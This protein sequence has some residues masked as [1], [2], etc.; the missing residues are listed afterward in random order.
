MGFL[1]GYHVIMI[2]FDENREELV[3]AALATAQAQGREEWF[4]V[5]GRSMR[6]LLREGDEIQV[7]FCSPENLR[8]GDLAVFWEGKVLTAHRILDIRKTPQDHLFLEK[9]DSNPQGR[10]IPSSR[11][12][13]V[14]Q[15][16]RKP[17]GVVGLDRPC[18]RWWNRMVAKAGYGFIRALASFLSPEK[19][20]TGSPSSLGPFWGYRS[21]IYLLLFLPLWGERIRA[22]FYSRFN[23]AGR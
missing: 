13:G 6:P 15:A 20:K 19:G 5:K 17:W 22:F 14:V 3:V 10:F 21:W 16:V 12:K 18:W 7:R 9:G 23:R 4:K 11:I 2:D 8:K 1:R